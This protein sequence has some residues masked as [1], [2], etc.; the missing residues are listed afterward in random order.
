VE[1]LDGLWWELTAIKA[2]SLGSLSGS[3]QLNLIGELPA[4]TMFVNT[5]TTL[6]P[7]NSVLLSVGWGLLNQ[8][9]LNTYR[10]DKFQVPFPIQEKVWYNITTTLMGGE[11]IAVAINDKQIFNVSLDSYYPTSVSGSTNTEGS[12][13]FGPYQDQ[14][15]LVKDVII[16]DSLNGTLLYRNSMTNPEEVLPE[17]GVHDNYASVCLDGAKRDRLLWLGDFY[18]TA[19]IVPISTGRSDYL[20]GTIQ[21]FVDWQ[22]T[23][24][25][26]FIAAPIGYPSS[27]DKGIWAT[28]GI[29]GLVDYQALGLMGFASYIKTS[30]DID[31]AKTSWPS[32]QLG[33]DLLLSSID[34]NGLPSF[35]G[36]GFIGPVVDGAAVACSIV[37]ALNDLAEVATFVGDIT[38]AS[39]WAKNAQA[40]SNA[41]NA[42]LW[43]SAGFYS[44]ALSDP[45]NFSVAALSFAITSGVASSARAEMALSHLASLKLGPGYKDSSSVVSDA[46]VNISPNTNGILLD[47]LFEANKTEL[48]KELI[49]SLWSPMVTNSETST[50]ASWEYVNQEGKPGL[51][52]FTSLSHPWG[53]A[54]TYLLTKHVAG[55]RQEN[56]S[57]G[58]KRWVIEPALGWGLGRLNAHVP[59]PNGNLGVS[60]IIEGGVAIVT[61]TSPKGTSGNLVIS[62][63][64]VDGLG[65]GSG[66]QIGE[67]MTRTVKVHLT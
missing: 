47:A 20:K 16:R 60:W 31:F 37:K 50:G 36:A 4:S 57:F 46:T 48:A 1:V 22:F 62:K 41:V 32:I 29:F 27:H 10:L 3:I 44:I 45:G 15:A 24:G 7:P 6:T 19:Q 25:D 12:F 52:L 40:L 38:S 35:I 8:T 63:G 18:H 64:R 5:N 51:G 17:F 55:I 28:P 30:A 53:G 2:M 21:E 34:S 11:Y 42:R 9:T 61:V 59:T 13:G 66:I 65:I 67:G 49:K 58:W 39:N 54:P 23:T 14:V 56:G 33:I 43:N 26:Y